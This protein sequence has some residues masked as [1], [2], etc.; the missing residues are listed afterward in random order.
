ML[1]KYKKNKNLKLNDIIFIMYEIIIFWKHQLI[2]SNDKI[3]K[4]LF[5]DNQFVKANVI[6]DDVKV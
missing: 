4:N 3:L 2:L 6:N 5:N 1:I